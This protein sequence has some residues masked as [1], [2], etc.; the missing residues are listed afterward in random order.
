MGVQVL[1]NYYESYK[2]T[3]N[4]DLQISSPNAAITIIDAINPI[5]WRILYP[6]TV[7]LTCQYEPTLIIH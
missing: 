1:W 7:L 5:Y 3:F 2:T 6:V 4:R